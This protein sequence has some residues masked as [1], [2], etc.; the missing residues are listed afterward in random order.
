MSKK[1]QD[2]STEKQKQVVRLDQIR[3]QINELKEQGKEQY[4][5]KIGRQIAQLEKEYKKVA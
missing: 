3:Q 2:H 5:P 4:K 1:H